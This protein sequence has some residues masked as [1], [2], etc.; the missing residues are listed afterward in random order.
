M[1][2]F[3]IPYK[4]CI[5]RTPIFPISDIKKS[6]DIDS[7][8]ANN[9]FSE[10]IY[11]SSSSLYE[12]V[13]K[14][15][16]TITERAQNS[17]LRY[18]SR[19]CTRATPYGLFAGCDILTVDMAHETSSVMLADY[20]D[21][22]TYTRIDMNILCELAR[23][24]E[25]DET[26]QKKLTYHINSTL[27]S[28]SLGYNYIEY[29]LNS[30]K[31][32]YTLSLVSKSYYLDKIIELLMDKQSVSYSDIIQYLIKLDVDR[33]VAESFITD[34]IKERILVSCLEPSVVGKDY[35]YQLIDNLKLL[36][37]S[38]HP[39]LKLEEELRKIDRIPLG[40]RIVNY[41]ALVN[42]FI[43]ND[44]P[45]IYH[46]D[47]KNTI[48]S[49]VIGKDIIDVVLECADFLLAIGQEKNSPM[50]L[51]INRFYERFE[52]EE[53]PLS[54]ALDP[55]VGIE[56]GVWHNTNGDINPLINDIP[57][58]ENRIYT[59]SSIN[60]FQ[61]VLMDKYDQALRNNEDT[62]DLKGCFGDETHLKKDKINFFYTIFSVVN[63]S[64]IKIHMSGIV[65]SSYLKLASRFQYLSPKIK[66]FIDSISKYEETKLSEDCIYAEILHLPEDRVGNIQIHPINRTYAIPYL[67]NAPTCENLNIIPISDILISTPNGKRVR[68]RSKKYNKEICPIL[69]TAH[70]YSFGLPLYA[71]LCELDTYNKQTYN[72][73]WGDWANGKKYLPRVCYGGNTILCPAQ[74]RLKHDD[75]LKIIDCLN[76]DKECISVI[77]DMYSLPPTF[78][79]VEGDNKL[80]VDLKVANLKKMFCHY[81]KSKNNILLEECLYNFHEKG[82]VTKDNDVFANEI[83]IGF[84]RK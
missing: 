6:E 46:V 75:C 73:Y 63:P 64:P 29:S 78:F 67:S 4:S 34:L 76:R 50:N 57:L 30:Y 8:V 31:R 17:L 44:Y 1:N 33:D 28:N 32:K 15:C 52:E 51:F 16:D 48:A 79:I 38:A 42:K 66:E 24:L 25:K 84:Y 82:F 80:F 18:Y 3:Y 9:L 58:P 12:K 49:G 47:I 71:F 14:K 54:I 11:L 53:I 5:L 74:W 77:Y 13:Y 41:D 59:Q 60:F 43:Q 65:D 7:V 81:I 68:L 36:G 27:Y 72:F 62:I 35:I 2:N 56:Y 70:N 83:L 22:E 26:V 39:F 40:Q 45:S 55:Q 23:L 10:A 37:I 20:S 69:S 61:Q 21:Y 19:A